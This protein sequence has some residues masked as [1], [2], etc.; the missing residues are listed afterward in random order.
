VI[1]FYLKIWQ[2]FGPFSSLKKAFEYVNIRFFRLKVLHK[3]ASFENGEKRDKSE[4]K[5]RGHETTCSF[6]DWEQ[7]VLCIIPF[8]K[9]LNYFDEVNSQS[10]SS[11]KFNNNRQFSQSCYEFFL[12]ISS[13][14][15]G[16]K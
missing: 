9:F 10:V 12:T 2:N 1:I 7:S 11:H 14:L 8:D 6:V 13:N 15:D 3:F 4:P 16:K 5:V